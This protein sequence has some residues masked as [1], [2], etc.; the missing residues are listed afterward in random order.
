ME[1]RRWRWRWRR[2][3]AGRGRGVERC[4]VGEGPHGPRRVLAAAKGEML[5]PGSRF[6]TVWS[7]LPALCI[8]HYCWLMLVPVLSIQVSDDT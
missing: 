8:C 7:G 4:R 1:R 3:C 6:M 2:G 5:T